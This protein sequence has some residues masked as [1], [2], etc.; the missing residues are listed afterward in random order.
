MECKRC[1][2]LISE[3][4][5][6]CNNCGIEIEKSLS[7][8]GETIDACSKLWFML[9]FIRGSFQD[10]KKGRIELEKFEN[11]LKNKLPGFFE[12][13]KRVFNH[14]VNLA[15]ENNEKNKETIRPKRKSI[16]SAKT[17]QKE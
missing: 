5:K 2:S 10:S 3:D 9:G 4:S 14:I 11:R 16:P 6:F 7:I 15:N 13:Y 17:V 8:V 12:D 1:G